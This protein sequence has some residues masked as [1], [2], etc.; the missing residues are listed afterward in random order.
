M[1]ILRI[2][3]S[4][5]AVNEKL[6]SA[7]MNQVD[8]NAT[9]AL[10]RRDGYSDTLSS[11][12]TVANGGSFTFGSGTS[13][14]TNS[15]A[16]AIFSGSVAVS[17]SGTL[18]VS[19]GATTTLAGTNNITGNTTFSTGT[20]TVNSATS[21]VGAVTAGNFTMTSL[22]KVKVALRSQFRTMTGLF[23]PE[24]GSSWDF[25]QVFLTNPTDDVMVALAPLDLPDNCILNT[26]IV[27]LKGGPSHSA[28]PSIL[29]RFTVYSINPEFGTTNPGDVAIDSSSDPTDYELVHG[30]SYSPASALPINRQTNKY[31]IRFESEGSTNAQ[32]NMRL[33]GYKVFY[34][35][36]EMDEF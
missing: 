16:S 4:S 35:V 15:G 11:T 7:Q 20:L 18:T 33:Y 26:V 14:A 21:L 6:T 5:W 23:I 29:P 32:V 28:L 27:Y 19:S 34:T 22:N 24:P 25:E 2:K 9:Y 1:T 17:S 13:I 31:I 8:T 10:D 30:I 12:V 3:P 36:T